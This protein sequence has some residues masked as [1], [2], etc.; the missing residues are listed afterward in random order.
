MHVDC[1]AQCLAHLKFSAV[2]GF[3]GKQQHKQTKTLTLSPCS[4]TWEANSTEEYLSLLGTRG[5]HANTSFPRT[6]VT[7]FP[8]WQSVGGWKNWDTQPSDPWRC[9]NDPVRLTLLKSVTKNDRSHSHSCPV[10]TS[11]VMLNTKHFNTFFL[12]PIIK[13]IQT[14]LNIWQVRKCTKNGKNTHLSIMLTT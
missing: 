11:E 7:F 10:W 9:D 14:F 2:D 1:S 12:S 6:V 13:I 5:H 8:V 3:K 4:C